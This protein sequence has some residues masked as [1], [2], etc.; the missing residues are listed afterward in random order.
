MDSAPPSTAGPRQVVALATAASCALGLV[1][2]GMAALPGGGNTRDAAILHGFTSLYRRRVD[3]ELEAIARVV[4][5]VPYAVGGMLCIAAA[6]VRRCGWRALAVGIVL[7]GTGL[8]TQALKHLLAEARYTPWLGFDQIQGASWPSGHAT[9][10]MAL[11]LCAVIAAP[12]RL[13]TAIALAA[14]GATVCVSYATLAL[15]WH[16]PSDALAGLLVAGL[17]VSLVQVVLARL[18]DD[19]PPMRLRAPPPALLGLGGAGALA[20]AAVVGLAADRPTLYSGERVTVVAG[21]LTIAAVVLGLLVA[22]VTA[23]SEPAGRERRAA[24][25]RPPSQPTASVEGDRTSRAGHAHAEHADTPPR[26]TPAHG[27]SPR[28]P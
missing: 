8:T 2:V 26:R 11:A 16:Y 5:V 22:T 6:L 17:W 9:A 21:A 4:D 7:A 24:S 18:E 13:R 27:R 14:G 3:T 10:A 1:A 25:P 20:A 23:D 28:A 15:L 19:T 12:P